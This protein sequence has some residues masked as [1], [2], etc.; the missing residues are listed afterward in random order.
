MVDLKE[1][2]CL[3]V[4]ACLINSSTSSCRP[5]TRPEY[6]PTFDVPHKKLLN[7]RIRLWCTNSDSAS[8]PMGTACSRFGMSFL[9]FIQRKEYQLYG[10]NAHLSA[11]LARKVSDRHEGSRRYAGMEAGDNSEDVNIRI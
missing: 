8:S 9:G 6:T 7:S 4:Y 3:K 11:S 10:A 1:P 5:G 2:R